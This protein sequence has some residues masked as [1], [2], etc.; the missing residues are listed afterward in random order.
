MKRKVKFSGRIMA[1][2]LS[3]AM[4]LTSVWNENLV[5]QAAYDDEVVAS[6][7]NLVPDALAYDNGWTNSTFT[8]GAIEPVEVDGKD[9]FK[10]TIGDGNLG[11]DWAHGFKYTGTYGGNATLTHGQSYQI[12][13]KAKSDVTRKIQSG[14]DSGQMTTR[15]TIQLTAGETK[16]VSYA[17]TAGVDWSNFYFFCGGVDTNETNYGDHTVT[18][19]DFAIKEATLIPLDG[20]AVE[21]TE[22]NLVKNGTFKDGTLD[23]WNVSTL[24]ATSKAA[25]YCA[26]FD[27]TG[28]SADWQT[29]MT[30]NVTLDTNTTYKIAFDV[31]STVARN[32]CA[33]FDPTRFEA[34]SVP[35]N[36][37]TTIEYTVSG[38]AGGNFA[39]FIGS[40]D[41]TLGAHR[42][43][44]S[45]VIIVPSTGGNEGGNT[46]GEGGGEEDTDTAS[47]AEI[48]ALK[49]AYDAAVLIKEAGK[50]ED[51]S[52]DVWNK[53]VT[54]INA[55]E[56]VLA[57]AEGE[58]GVT[59]EA[60][61]A[62]LANLK[63]AQAALDG[64]EETPG[65]LIK[66]G[67]F[68]DGLK[69]WGTMSNA[70]TVTETP[71]SITFDIARDD[72]DWTSM[73]Y[74][75]GVTLDSGAKYLI[76]F[77][78][79][80]SVAREL[81]AGF[82]T[83]G[84]RCYG[85]KAV[86][87]NEKTTV[88]Y[89]VDGGVA[90]GKFA[91]FLG[92]NYN[93]A[94]DPTFG[95]TQT[96]GAH[97]VVL[98]NVRITKL[99]VDL[100]DFDT[101]N[102]TYPAAITNLNG[103]ETASPADMTV[104]KNGSFK[105]GLAN[106]E[107]YQVD[108]M[109]TWMPVTF[110]S[111]EDGM[112]VKIVKTG[113]ELPAEDNP[114]SGNNAWDVQLNQRIS[115]KKGLPY[116][117]S[118]KVTS[119]KS[120]SINIVI[121]H[122]NNGENWVKPI[123]IPE[124]ETR[125]VVLNLPVLSEDAI[126]KLFSFQMGRVNEFGVENND[127]LFEDIK[128]EVH[129]YQ[130]LAETIADGDFDGNE[131]GSFVFNGNE[132]ASVTVSDSV[133]VDV[134]EDCAAQDVTLTRG[135]I[136]L[137]AGQT[138][139]F[140]FNAGDVQE[141]SVTVNVKDGN[142]AV[143]YT[144]DY[145]LTNDV[146]EFSF[147]YTP[148]VDETVSLEFVMGGEKNTVCLDTIRCD[149]KGFAAAAGIDTGRHDITALD[150][151]VAPVISEADA[152][153][154]YAGQDIVLTYEN[155][156]AFTAAI[157]S[158]VVAGTEVFGTD[159]IAI[160]E[161]DTKTTITLDESLFVVE[162]DSDIFV[163]EI[164]AYWYE[165]VKVLQTV[166]KE[167][168]WQSTWLEEFDGN[169]LDTTKWSYQNGTGVEY[170]IAG[171]GNNEQQYYTNNNITVD[172]GALTIV[173][174]KDGTYNTKYTS[175][176]IWTMNDDRET[177]KF[178]QKYGRMEAKIKVPG[179]EGYEGIW[180]AFWMLP[181]D[182]S[183]YGGWPLSGEI[184]I[185]EIRGR[186]PDEVAGTIHYGK[187]YPNNANSGGS[188]YFSESD[189]NADSDV[190]DYHVYAL[191]WEPGEI[192]WY[193]DGELYCTQNNWY[194]QAAGNPTE[195]AYPAPFD[196]EFYIILNLA[197]GGTFDGNREPNAD[198][199]PAEMVVDYVRVYEST[200]EYDENV[201]KPDV[202]KDTEVDWDAVKSE[203]IDP[204]FENVTV[205]AD[206]N[207][208]QS[209]TGW[210]FVT[211]PD[212][213]GAATLTT[214]TEGEDTLAKIDITKGGVAHAVQLIQN[215]GL[216]KG[217]CY[218]LSFDAKADASRKMSIKLGD[219]GDDD[220]AT[221]STHEVTLTPQLQHYE[222]SFQMTADTDL[223]SRV[224]FNLGTSTKT[225]YIGNVTLEIV[226]E[227]T[228]DYD[229][230]K[231]ALGDENQIYNGEFKLGDASRLAYWHLS[232]DCDGKV[233]TAGEGVYAFEATKGE[234][235]QKGIQLLQNDSYE[236]TFDAYVAGDADADKDVTITVMNADGSSV[237]AEKVISMAA[238][239][240]AQKMTFTMEEG[241]SDWSAVVEFAFENSD[242]AAQI[243]DIR[244][245]KTSYNNVDWDNLNAYPLSNG[246]FEAGTANW[247]QYGNNG[248]AVV[249]ETGNA[250]NHVAKVNGY[251]GG[252]AWGS[253]LTYDGLQLT[254][255][256]TYEFSFEAWADS[257]QEI[258]VTM[259]DSTY[260]KY[261][262]QD[263]I[264]IGTEKAKYNYTF[265]LDSDQNVAL[266]FQFGGGTS[267]Y[268][269]YVDNVCLN[270]KGAPEKPGTATAEFSNSLGKDVVITLLGEDAWKNGIRLYLGSEELPQELFTVE[271][272]K[273]TIDKSVFDKIGEYVFEIKSAG[274]AK[275][276]VRV[277]IYPASGNVF[278]NGD[279]HD[280][281]TGWSCWSKDNSGIF[282]D[283]NGRMGIEY[284]YGARDGALYVPWSILAAYEGIAVEKGKT[285]EIS[286]LAESEIARPIMVSTDQGS[287]E[288]HNYVN[289]TEGEGAYKV[290]FEST[291]TIVKLI[292]QTGT[293]GSESQP[294]P[295]EAFAPHKMYFDNVLIREVVEGEENPLYT[296]DVTKLLEEIEGLNKE[297]Y[298]EASWNEF[299]QKVAAIKAKLETASTQAEIEKLREELQAAVD[300]L[301][302]IPEGLW[303]QFVEG[304]TYTYT[305]SAIKPAVQVYDGAVLL[306]KKDYSVSYK[307]N[308]KA[309]TATITVTGK[310][311]YNGKQTVNFTIEPKDITAEE[312][313]Y[314]ILKKDNILPTVK[315]T[316]TTV[317]NGKVKKLST[318]DYDIEYSYNKDSKNPDTYDA[319]KTYTATVTGKDNYTGTITYTT[320]FVEGKTALMKNAKISLEYTKAD[321]T[322]EELKPAVTV[323][324]NNNPVDSSWYKA[325]YSD[326]V[327]SAGKVTVTVTGDNENLFGTKTA[328]YTIK[329]KTL[330]KVA[331]ITGVADL[332]YADSENGQMQENL[333]VVFKDE[334]RTLSEYD[335]E[336]R[337]GDYI[338]SY[339]K[340]TKAGTAKVT[341]TGVGEFEGT[342]SKSFKITKPSITEVTCDSTAVYTKTGAIATGVVVKAGEK[343][344]TEGQDYKLSYSNNKKAGAVAKLTVQGK[345]NYTGKIT[346]TTYT[347]V[348]AD[349]EDAVKV[350]TTDAGA[351]TKYSK[352]KV[353][354]F[355]NG[356]KLSKNEYT[357]S[358]AVDG[359]EVTDLDSKVEAGKTVEVTVTATGGNYNAG[360][361]KT[362]ELYVGSTNLS[363]AK[364]KVNTTFYYLG[365][366]EG[367]AVTLTGDDLT[368]TVTIKG[369]TDT[370]EYGE[371]YVILGE[372]YKN[373]DKKGTASVTIKGMG[374]YYG[375]K[376]VKFAIKQKDVKENWFSEALSALQN[377]F[378]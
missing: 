303:I 107:T 186:L 374:D 142:S 271:G 155:D 228:V 45:N 269:A 101:A 51:C 216:V 143:K 335:A 305:G 52:E 123:G 109:E 239:E 99:P 147:E 295:A 350:Q 171:W 75:E 96:L 225:A 356:K 281:L 113:D 336:T 79:E 9:G 16:E 219:L 176:R 206:N 364:Y 181:V 47:E 50:E 91:I 301:E 337:Q 158:V 77:D 273:L 329:G 353:T 55:A 21:E 146:K 80:S 100:S 202:E 180:P 19:W 8:S 63:A 78:V 38:I 135:G 224:E 245:V 6:E 218:K 191:E 277:N 268:T 310:G 7:T 194:S 343:I 73:I 197:V 65:N 69:N 339:T 193:V 226:D 70:C 309:G 314:G 88:E 62:A 131:I 148:T 341:V 175:G 205:V 141:K 311:N 14:C 153:S 60:V 64:V 300:A 30:Q 307:D 40:E 4:V 161:G 327:I 87:A 378:S 17:I 291:S 59:S 368:V 338:V 221:Y 22:G 165:D 207:T 120:R 28:I 173:A 208:E 262:T 317:I 236:L 238:G 122:I 377:F 359:V 162:G 352:L 321:W 302:K 177:A 145:A 103:Y 130:A 93:N 89:T 90:N 29:W 134:N 331:K 332:P 187:D 266:K 18:I 34:K 304:D 124:G 68:A 32:I 306:D 361:Q 323:K 192:R 1:L 182:T 290:T 46:G 217:Y 348:A 230:T 92:S 195:F 346:T 159:K 254:G 11:A 151:F 13:F 116:T 212:F 167:N 76:Q 376:T 211:L 213:G 185:M 61:N 95:K 97:R 345:G 340:N 125:E 203:I 223:T 105:N 139:R 144:Q 41:G 260:N 267:A 188:Y 373:N 102:D 231:P 2:V 163:I 316:V 132:K 184:D 31:E 229:G 257:A 358:Y 136:S 263:N 82:D 44:I 258:L 282:T 320:K 83:V 190:N 279:F 287:G 49:S 347:V 293:V 220:W 334:T 324:V 3:A 127:L 25:K 164:G 241:V 349:F 342:L 372:T 42:V 312:T 222:Y 298:L 201:V 227:V 313:I 119:N 237:Y 270:M 299:E 10:L 33:G 129:G 156:A 248:F 150:K 154:A 355:D 240:S 365:K 297:E 74:Q 56:E 5:V 24:N 36:E 370:L 276:T 108:W 84:P 232:D 86:P 274:Y 246:D 326:D 264:A 133:K 362:G 344:L 233:V 15:E 117:L 157:D 284:V 285:Y 35:A 196:Q 66:N 319:E 126:D 278:A 94:T 328:T 37:K 152:A 244:L 265:K 215:I 286:F 322:G 209:A 214:V 172:D 325:E 27:I 110:K 115:L 318:K 39:I 261:F 111:T 296:E 369:V 242:V 57:Q 104:I 308:K 363:K 357:V 114:N 255:G 280:G 360:T 283:E 259:E 138:Y 98:S 249:E 235:Y 166:Y 367:D 330:S 289:L 252:D 288:V 169:A 106:W 183:I 43:S 54:A 71:Y 371:D 292:F 179:G 67:T 168:K 137:L 256:T 81:F 275:T 315:P 160:A 200:E 351:G 210:N 118:F 234:L 174:K 251:Q 253:M 140:S 250:S 199:L 204:D 53:F 23:N 12:S 375:T 26:I 272:D 58:E 189:V 294:N 178:S 149:L 128:L 354:V 20:E 170:G 198:N 333:Q 121:E 112:Q 243:S 247:G 72:A 85:W 366:E 48:V